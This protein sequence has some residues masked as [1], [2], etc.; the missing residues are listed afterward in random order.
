MKFVGNG[1]HVFAGYWYLEIMD[2]LLLLSYHMIFFTTVENWKNQTFM[3]EVNNGLVRNS[4]VK[5]FYKLLVERPVVSS[6]LIPLIL[7]MISC[8]RRR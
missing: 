3:K 8:P 6:L 2:F 5:L 7:E 1:Q 4:F